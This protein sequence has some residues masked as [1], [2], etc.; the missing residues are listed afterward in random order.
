MSELSGFADVGLSR[1]EGSQGPKA[2]DCLKVDFDLG[3]KFHLESQYAQLHNM[4]KYL[5][6]RT[7]TS[8]HIGFSAWKSG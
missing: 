7:K 5:I 1:V 3:L 6:L 8:E 4:M 2:A